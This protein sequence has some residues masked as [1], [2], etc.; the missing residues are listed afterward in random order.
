MKNLRKQIGWLFTLSVLLLTGCQQEDFLSIP[1]GNDNIEVATRA[2]STYNYLGNAN[3][4]FAL[5][6]GNMTNENGTLSF[7]DGSSTTFPAQNW[8]YRSQNPGMQMGNVPQDLFVANNK[9]YVIAQN[10]NAQSGAKHI[11]VTNNMLQHVTDFNPNNYFAGGWSGGGATPTHLAVAGNKIFVR[12]NAGVV[13]TSETAQTTTPAVIAGIT[14]PSRIRMAMVN[15]GGTKYLYVGGQDNKVYRINTTSNAV[16]SIAVEGKVAGLTA[17][18]RNNNALQ[19]VWALCIKSD[20]TTVLQKISGTT[21][22]SGRT[23]A[24]SGLTFDANLFIPSVG[25]CC[26]AGGASDVLYFRTNGWDPKTVYKYNVAT[27]QTTSFYT[28]PNGIDS[29]ARIIYGDL[30]VDPNTGDVYFGYVGDWG[31]YASVN[32][33]V[34]LNSTGGV[35]KEYRSSYSAPYK[36]D[37]RFTAGI[38]FTKEF[39]M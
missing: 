10:G 16:Q 26:Y 27:N 30:G 13:V 37:T 6:E 11:L 36:I 8:V 3:G 31:V 5:S 2:V 18:R 22:E 34:K 12:T 28:V 20:G 23:I 4:I 17:V 7:I 1:A 19:Y 24:A 21:A 38:Y 25:L 14:N 15:N 33:V 32:G 39:S 9:M 35:A 29:R